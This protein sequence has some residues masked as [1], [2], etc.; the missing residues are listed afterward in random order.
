MARAP[1]ELMLL[2]LLRVGAFIVRAEA[3]VICPALVK[4]GTVM[5][6]LPSLV[7]CP[8]LP[9]DITGVVP[10]VEVTTM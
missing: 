6:R 3:A 5:V 10:L 7:R 9:S 2:E 4:L 8:V 1:V